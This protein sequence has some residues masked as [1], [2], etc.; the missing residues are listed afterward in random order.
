M[1]WEVEFWGITLIAENNEDEKLLKELQAK[2]P[3]ELEWPVNRPTVEVETNEDTGKFQL[4]F[5]TG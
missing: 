3:K 2:L 4:L 1:K 5:R